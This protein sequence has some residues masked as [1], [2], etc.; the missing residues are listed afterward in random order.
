V[1]AFLEEQHL[2]ERGRRRRG[3]PR[4]FARGHGDPSASSEALDQI[5]NLLRP[6]LGGQRLPDPPSALRDVR[7]QQDVDRGGQAPWLELLEWKRRSC[8]E[9]RDPVTLKRT[10]LRPGQS[11]GWLELLQAKLTDVRVEVIPGVGHFTQIDSPARV[12][13]LIAGFAGARRA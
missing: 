9:L 3:S 11:S 4:R 7:T 2:D 5:G 12:N 6:V 8:S 13:S 10:S 1:K